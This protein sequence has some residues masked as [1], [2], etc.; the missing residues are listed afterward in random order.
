MDRTGFQA[1]AGSAGQRE[2]SRRRVLQELGEP[3]WQGTWKHGT[4]FPNIP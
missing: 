2:P 3:E 1:S 4:E